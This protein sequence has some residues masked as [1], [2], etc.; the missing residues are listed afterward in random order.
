M[1]QRGQIEVGWNGAFEVCFRSE[2]CEPWATSKIGFYEAEETIMFLVSSLLLPPQEAGKLV[3][4]AIA[5]GRSV[6]EKV[7]SGPTLH[8][9]IARRAS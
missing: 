1:L 2:S 6:S 7:V 3:A 4:E 8:F 5:E 9:A